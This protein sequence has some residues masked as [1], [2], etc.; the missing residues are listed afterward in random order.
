MSVK[1]KFS[2]AKKKIFFSFYFVV[3]MLEESSLPNL[4]FM[5]LQR[6]LIQL[7]V[8]LVTL[9]GRFGNQADQFLGA[10]RFAKALDRTLV[11]PHWVEYRRAAASSSVC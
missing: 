5:N 10:L 2:I 4:L 1:Q 9:T 8:L 3:F 7:S 11:L 6:V